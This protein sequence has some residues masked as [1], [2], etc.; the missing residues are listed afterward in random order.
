[1][2]VL[3]LEETIESTILNLNLLY[4]L[5]KHRGHHMLFFQYFGNSKKII[6]GII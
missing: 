5:K 1:M 4:F 6:G 3:F 2:K